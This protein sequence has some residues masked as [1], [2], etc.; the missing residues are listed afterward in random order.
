MNP[1]DSF[2]YAPE[3]KAN[4]ISFQKVCEDLLERWV[5]QSKQMRH[6]GLNDRKL[7]LLKPF[8]SGLGRESAFPLM[9]LILPELDNLRDKYG[10]KTVK[11]ASLFAEL[12]FPSKSGPWYDRLQKYTDPEK[13]PSPG[14]ARWQVPGDF[15]LTLE[16][17]LTQKKR[18]VSETKW[19][20]GDVNKALTDLAAAPNDSRRRQVL[21]RI[22]SECSPM[23]QKWIVRVILKNL[24]IN[25]K[26]S[27]LNKIHPDA[28][29]EYNRTT[30]LRKVCT[31][32]IGV[33][34]S[35]RST[36]KI[37]VFTSFSPMLATNFSY[38]TDKKIMPSLGRRPFCMDVKLDG[39]RM[40]CHRE[41]NKVKWFTRNAK[42]YTEKY[43][44]ALTPQILAGVSAHKCVLDGEVVTW[45]DNSGSM[46]PFGNNRTYAK[47]ELEGKGDGTRRL[48]YVVFD[49]L[50]AE[51]GGE[52][53][54]KGGTGAADID[55]MV[56]DAVRNSIAPCPPPS[57]VKAGN[58]TALPL[59]VRRRVLRSVVSER[60][61]RLELVKSWEV[62]E[63]DEA[64]RKKQLREC[65][66]QRAINLN[67]EGLVVKD[68]H[69]QYMLGDKSRKS[70]LWIKM[71]PEY[72]GQ[73]EDMD[74]L[75]LAAGFANGE[76]RSGLL[77]KFLVG[78]AAPNEEGKPRKTFYPVARVGTGYTMN[79]IEDLNQ[80][81]QGKWKTF[82]SEPP[83]FFPHAMAIK[84]S[85]RDGTPLTRWIAPEDSICLQVKCME[86]VR[87]NDWPGVFCTMRFPR[88]S[89]IRKDKG[90]EGCIDTIEL[91]AVQ[92]RPR[93][94]FTGNH[95]NTQG[96]HGG[97]GS[98]RKSG[99]GGDG[100]GGGRGRRGG[101]AGKQVSELFAI[102]GGTVAVKEK[103]FVA[104]SDSKRPL[105]MCVMVDTFDP[106]AHVAAD[107]AIDV[108]AWWS[109]STELGKRKQANRG[110]TRLERND[111]ELLIREH[112]GTVTANPMEQTTSFVVVGEKISF[113]V[114]G[115]IDAKKWNVVD[116]RWVLGCVERKTYEFPAM[117]HL[118]A[119]SAEARKYFQAIKDEFGDDYLERTDA[120]SL[121]KLMLH[122]NEPSG[123][124][125]KLSESAWLSPLQELDEMEVAKLEDGPDFLFARRCLVYCDL[126]TDLGPAEPPAT[127]NGDGGGDG[128]GNRE[129]IPFNS[130][131]STAQAVRL[132]GGEVARS[133][134][135]G[136][137]HVVVDPDDT[138]RLGAIKERIS[139][140]HKR[141]GQKFHIRVVKPEWAWE[142]IERG[143][144]ADPNPGHKIDLSGSVGLAG[145]V[146][147][148]GAL[149]MR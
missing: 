119:M 147:G 31:K 80:V 7:E 75:I 100:E 56:R 19:T 146:N 109:N 42:D 14:D 105:E 113:R 136:V 32:F 27:V 111:L 124:R 115:I 37:E 66:E 129:D 68:L 133:L 6:K 107:E 148:R 24:K 13:N 8:L 36:T 104:A 54:A 21:N 79:E 118:R 1:S 70:A 114:R 9:R 103:V 65:F 122:I 20:I 11:I 126:F 60:E 96:G 88:V 120:A 26:K 145:A 141:E 48:F 117:R 85:S 149:Y 112:G 108:D 135:V 144:L 28:L 76:M 91:A 130:L 58:L 139:D 77:S 82:D 74:V 38:E 92:A 34:S 87:A 55:E 63:G 59:D 52:E 131:G 81:L 143:W 22:R 29:D 110:G 99:S 89:H 125:R 40:L 5:T 12:N 39:E 44:A 142:C 138:A 72:S 25:M 15:A 78:V 41:G 128:D 43:G 116:Y 17:V 97:S 69:G 73:T 2:E 61:H 93:L 98:R 101:G 94:A 137:T 30:S 90:M 51:G 102:A 50:L 86:I 121:S 45:D 49:I 35:I 33:H 53:E 47:E 23:N 62:G 127:A 84:R 134:Y 67:E 140:L 132:Y 16:Y 106:E 18:G 71:K 123:A 10:M 83:H 95:N 3:T 4:E 57:E 46:V 64:E